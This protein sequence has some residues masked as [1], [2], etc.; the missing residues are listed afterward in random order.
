MRSTYLV[1]GLG[2]FLK[3]VENVGIVFLL[4]GAQFVEIFLWFRH[5]CVL[6]SRVWF[7]W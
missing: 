3:L 2:L 7:R 4:L 1:K 6:W 5:G